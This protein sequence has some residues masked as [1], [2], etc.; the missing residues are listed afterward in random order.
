MFRMNLP[1]FV[2]KIYVYQKAI[3]LSMFF[4]LIM[5]FPQNINCW[6]A[7]VLTENYRK[8]VAIMFILINTSISNNSLPMF[9]SHK[10]TTIIQIKINT[11]N[12]KD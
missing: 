1:F 7:T 12:Q 10:S 9:K 4:F 3:I 2:H 6:S 8:A 11:I 5:I